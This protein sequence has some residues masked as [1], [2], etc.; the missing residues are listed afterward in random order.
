[1]EGRC[2]GCLL[3]KIDALLLVTENNYRFYSLSGV[4]TRRWALWSCLTAKHVYCVQYVAPLKILWGTKSLPSVSYRCFW[5]I[6]SLP[7]VSHH[8]FWGIK[9]L[10]SVSHHC[11]WGIKNLPSVSHHCFEGLRAY[12]RCLT[13]V[14]EGLRAYPRCLTIVFNL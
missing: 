5:G 10:P 3:W 9:S 13:I 11:F 1:M 2:K 14:F 4:A 12:L 7:S 6:K 8:C